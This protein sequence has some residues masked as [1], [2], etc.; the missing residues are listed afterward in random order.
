MAFLRGPT[1]HGP[2]RE[3]YMRYLAHSTNYA[4]IYTRLYT[5]LKPVTSAF[6]GS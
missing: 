2:V 5:R 4:R 3:P 1:T 6:R